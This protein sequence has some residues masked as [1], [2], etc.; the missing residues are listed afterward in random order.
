MVR[1]RR[2]MVLG[3]KER[4][5]AGKMV[6]E[7]PSAFSCW[8]EARHARVRTAQKLIRILCRPLRPSWTSSSKISNYSLYFSFSWLLLCSSHTRTL[9]NLNSIQFYQPATTT[10]SPRKRV[11]KTSTANDLTIVERGE[12]PKAPGPSDGWD[13]QW[14]D[15]FFESVDI[16]YSPSR[17]HL[18]PLRQEA[19]DLEAIK[20]GL[21]GK[22]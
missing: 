6:R 10:S 11:S 21:E 14:D 12:L 13:A 9:I 16:A 2:S 8:E 22:I 19:S 20:A 17:K 7:W 15:D 18:S 5:Q 1:D 3:R 4:M